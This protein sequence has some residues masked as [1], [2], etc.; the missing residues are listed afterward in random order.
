MFWKICFHHFFLLLDFY[1]CAEYCCSEYLKKLM[2]RFW[3]GWLQ[4]YGQTNT[5]MNSQAWIHRTSPSV[6]SKNSHPQKIL[7]RQSSLQEPQQKQE[8]DKWVNFYLDKICCDNNSEIVTFLWMLFCYVLFYK[9][10]VSTETFPYKTQ[11]A[12]TTSRKK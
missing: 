1:C 8:K 11:H 2:N 12:K 9:E 7:W 6:G 3:K 4:K 5:L 10:M